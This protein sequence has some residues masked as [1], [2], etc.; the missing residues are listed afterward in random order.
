VSGQVEFYVVLNYT[1][2]DLKLLY[3]KGS[4]YERKEEKEILDSL[5]GKE[6]AKLS[7]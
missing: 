3:G 7:V 1:R 5:F 4:F 6:S 2:T